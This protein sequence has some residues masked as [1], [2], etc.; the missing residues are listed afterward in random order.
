MT[1]SSENRL[2]TQRVLESCALEPIVAR[3]YSDKESAT[4]VC[5]DDPPRS[6]CHIASS[7]S[8]YIRVRA[9][10]IVAEKQGSLYRCQKVVVVHLID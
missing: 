2:S 10:Y 1:E 3:L 7:S 9:R 8:D 4:T 6:Y 5:S